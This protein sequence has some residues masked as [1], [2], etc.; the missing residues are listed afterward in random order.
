MTVYYEPNIH[1]SF[2]VVSKK[3]LDMVKKWPNISCTRFSKKI[4]IFVF[5]SF[6]YLQV[7]PAFNGAEKV[8]RNQVKS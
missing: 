5:Y 4:G 8:T 3:R 1:E 7:V 2:Y 6:I